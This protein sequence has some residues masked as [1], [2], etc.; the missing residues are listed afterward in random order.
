MANSTEKIIRDLCDGDA[1]DWPGS[2]KGPLRTIL[3]KF[4]D[5]LLK[6]VRRDLERYADGLHFAGALSEE[7]VL[8]TAIKRIFN[9]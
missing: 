6:N 3:R 8:R 2:Y 1:Y 5:I 7:K 4:A 9:E